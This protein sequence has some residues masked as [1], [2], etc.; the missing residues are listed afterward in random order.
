MANVQEVMLDSLLKASRAAEQIT[1]AVER[2]KAFTELAKACAMALQTKGS[3]EIPTTEAS[4]ETSKT[5][6]RS[7]KKT[8]TPVV[9]EKKEEELKV[10][11]EPEQEQKKKQESAP[12]QSLVDPPAPAEEKTPEQLEAEEYDFT[13]E[14]TPKACEI[15]ANEIAE[16]QRYFNMFSGDIATFN[17]MVS[18]ATEGVSTDIDTITPLNIR[19]VLQYIK[20]LETESREEG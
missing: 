5:A 1:P 12:E 13:N 19:I 6:K 9:E 14:W 8:L 3:M 2:A 10:E 18:A 15:M 4:K 7:T 17:S 20:A 11:P 16:I